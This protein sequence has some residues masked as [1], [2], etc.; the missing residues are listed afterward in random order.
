MK[1][2]VDGQE[3]ELVITDADRGGD[4]TEEYLNESGAINDGQF[5]WDSSRQFYRTTPEVFDSWEKKIAEHQ[6][7]IDATHTRRRS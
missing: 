6:R 3:R 4:F 2:L 7:Q 1:I 5:V